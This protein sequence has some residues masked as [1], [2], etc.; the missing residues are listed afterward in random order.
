MAVVDDKDPQIAV[1]WEAGTTLS[2]KHA[3]SRGF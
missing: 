1:I 3:V 2:P